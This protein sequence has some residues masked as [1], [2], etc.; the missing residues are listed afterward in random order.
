MELQNNLA[1]RK[2]TKSCDLESTLDGKKELSNYRPIALLPIA[3][4]VLESVVCG[5]M[6]EFLETQNILPAPAQH[7][8][9][10][11]RS[12]TTAVLSMLIQWRSDLMIHMEVGLLAFDLCSAFGS[13]DAIILSGKM[14]ILG[15]D[16]LSI[17]WTWSFLSGRSQR[18][19]VKNT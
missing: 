5:R 4:K 2:T 3:S 11:K 15:F 18:V 19:V 13:L 8:F 14:E 9:R 7:G 10:E 1:L 17:K 6:S 12:P 16:H